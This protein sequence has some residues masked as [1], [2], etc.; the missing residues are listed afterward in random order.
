MWPVAGGPPAF[1]AALSEE[2]SPLTGCVAFNADGSK[3]AACGAGQSCLV[4]STNPFKK[5]PEKPQ[6]AGGGGTAL[7][8]HP[9]DLDFLLAADDYPRYETLPRDPQ[10]IPSLGI[11]F[12]PHVCRQIVAPPGGRRWF[13]LEESGDVLICDT[14]GTGLL[15]S[16]PTDKGGFD[17]ALDRDGNR[18]A[19]SLESG[20]I[21]I[22]DSALPGRPSL[23]V[24]APGV[25]SA[26]RET[27]VLV[28]YQGQLEWSSR[29]V[30]IDR[31]DRIHLLAHRMQG[32]NVSMLY[33]SSGAD[34]RALP[35]IVDEY[36][37][38]REEGLRL[39]L[40]QDQP[41]AIYR[42][43]DP[44]GSLDQARLRVARR[45]A[46]GWSSEDLAGPGN[47]AYFPIARL[48][49]GRLHEVLHFRFSGYDL[50]LTVRGVNGWQT[51]PI[52][53]QG[54]GFN[55]QG[56]PS[57]SLPLQFGFRINRF[58][59]DHAP[60]LFAS[61]DG[62]ELTREVID[63]SCE[64]LKAFTARE[65]SPLA[66]ALLVDRATPRW[67]YVAAIR[68]AAGQWGSTPFPGDA[69]SAAM[70]IDRD[71]CVQVLTIEATGEMKLWK[72]SDNAWSPE[73]IAIIALE[74][75]VNVAL[76]GDSRDRSIVAIGAGSVGP[77][78]VTSISILRRSP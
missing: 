4:F 27:H 58:N 78:V 48:Q 38:E 60:P 56:P 44:N 43:R 59:A 18:L 36:G 76:L 22:I 51:R 52:G 71:G 10:T 17:L 75:W 2:A 62:R 69:L 33:L 39:V 31:H 64:G 28:D 26:W 34:G 12:R 70:R 66:A 45:G 13:L 40:E 55:T 1:S 30:V 67:R 9:R 24:A 16:F 42:S 35:E 54:D 50:L 8:W 63:T 53:H 74:N 11:G 57:A 37:P 61:W 72:W 7:A 25:A 46:G 49:E 47:L 14:E 19:V 3:L 21:Q 6:L 41:V 65:D 23:R 5:L 32:A 15:W 29:G 20:E 73:K 77:D 68:T